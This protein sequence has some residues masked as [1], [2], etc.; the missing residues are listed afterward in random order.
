MVCF[1]VGMAE[2]VQ[3]VHI[4]M[5]G[6]NVFPYLV[7]VLLGDLAIPILSLHL[8]ILYHHTAFQ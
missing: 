2:S 8:Y 3:Y 5:Q 6:R 7:Y 4:T 1:E